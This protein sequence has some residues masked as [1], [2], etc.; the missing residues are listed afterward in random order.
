MP[1]A[2]RGRVGG[3]PLAYRGGTWPK[4]R[5]GHRPS[6]GRPGTAQ[7]L[8]PPRRQAGGRLVQPGPHGVPPSGTGRGNPV[9]GGGRQS[10]SDCLSESTIRLALCFGPCLQRSGSGRCA[11]DT[12]KNAPLDAIDPFPASV[13]TDFLQ[14]LLEIL[15][16]LVDVD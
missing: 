5:Q 4:P 8:R 6:Q 11:L 15:Q 10:A 1:S 14:L 3:P 13:L 12:W 9:P 16:Y 2:T 7:E